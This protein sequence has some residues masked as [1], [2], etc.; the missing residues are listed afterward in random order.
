MEAIMEITEV[1][2]TPRDGEGRLRGF[3]NITFDDSFVVRGIRI[4][5]GDDGLFVSM[6][7]HRKP[8]G[9]YQDIAHPINNEAR[10]VIENRIISAYNNA[11]ADGVKTD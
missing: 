1:R 2:I 7:S 4:V 10:S 3:A 5:E 9:T 8:D 11:I 6:P